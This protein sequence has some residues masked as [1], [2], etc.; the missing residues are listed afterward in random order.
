MQY[1]VGDPEVPPSSLVP[2]FESQQVVQTGVQDVELFQFFICKTAVSL[3]T[4]KPSSQSIWQVEMPKIGLRNPIVQHN[5]I[6]I[7]S[8]D[9]ARRLDPTTPQHTF[10]LAKA[11][12]QLNLA[13]PEYRAAIEDINRTNCTDLFASAIILSFYMFADSHLVQRITSLSLSDSSEI[14]HKIQ[15]VSGIFRAMR[16]T[17]M[18]LNRS[19]PWILS[20]PLS[21]ILEPTNWPDDLMLNNDFALKDD[22]RL[23]RLAQ[24]WSQSSTG[25]DRDVQALAEAHWLLRYAFSLVTNIDASAENSKPNL[26]DESYQPAHGTWRSPYWRAPDT[27]AL[28]NWPLRFKAH[29]LRLVDRQ[30]PFALILVAHFAILIHRGRSHYWWLEGISELFVSSAQQAIGVEM[31]PWIRWPI[32]VVLENELE[33]L[34]ENSNAVA[35]I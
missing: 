14:S 27:G 23:A 24:L 35:I 34:S 30:N 2:Y 28:F 21:A 22:A 25:A 26:I 17:F 18:V 32:K 1:G 29:F 7:A 33:T 8:L 5:L 10:L 31:L 6:A 12:R 20:G 19:W 13:L 15:M 3:S 16:G 11:A 9:Y 4:F